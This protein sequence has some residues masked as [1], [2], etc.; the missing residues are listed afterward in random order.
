MEPDHAL[1]DPGT[2][3]VVDA[4]HGDAERCRKVHD[5]VHLLAEDLAERPAV[6]REVLAEDADPPVVDRPHADDDAVGVGAAALGNPRRPRPGEHV[7][8]LEGA[9][10]EEVVEALA[11][12][13]LPASVLAL[14]RGRAPRVYRRLLTALQLLEPFGHCVLH[15]GE[16]YRS[17]ARKRK[18]AWPGPR[19][20]RARRAQGSST[21]SIRVPKDAL[22]WTKATVVP[23]EPGR[24]S[25][26]MVLPPWAWTVASAAAQSS[27][28]YPT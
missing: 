17:T 21:S 22:G 3:T 12:G 14:D 7:E 18:A 10:V 5:F 11:G 8:L 20:R 25:W 4:D 27:T 13:H 24:G 9:L 26:S 1:L 16:G 23:L 2:A 19:V 15:G 28:R 6:D